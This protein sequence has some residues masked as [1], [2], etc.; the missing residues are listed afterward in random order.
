M[1]KFYNLL[2]WF[3]YLHSKI[4]KSWRAHLENDKMSLLESTIFSPEAFSWQI[5]PKKHCSLPL[6]PNIHQKQTTPFSLLE[7][8]SESSR[9]H[10]LAKSIT[11]AYLP[12]VTNDRRFHM[13]FH[14]VEDWALVSISSIKTQAETGKLHSFLRTFK[15][16]NT[17]T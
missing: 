10:F 11:L 6:S 5:P 15:Q 12:G 13:R 9:R 2:T 14:A 17:S 8:K 16:S 1:L 4:T 7:G 3:T